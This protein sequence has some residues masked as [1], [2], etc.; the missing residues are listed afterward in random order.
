M[1]A[2]QAPDPQGGLPWG[3]RVVRTTRGETCVQIARLDG[4]QLGQLG[5]DGAFHD[6]GRFHP[7][8]PD[9][10]PSE[11]DSGDVTCDLSGQ[12]VVGG[13]EAVTAARR[14]LRKAPASSRLPRIC[15]QSHGGCWDHTP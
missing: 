15:D 8:A 12:I 7:L 2:L 13:W 10:L 3:M 4:D 11:S 1:L 14:P 6:D 5:I 9:V